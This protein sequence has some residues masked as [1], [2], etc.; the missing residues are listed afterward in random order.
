MVL[1]KEN[2][3]KRN[4][5]IGYSQGTWLSLVDANVTVFNIVFFPPREQAVQCLLPA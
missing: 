1:R 2:Y 3:V 5:S 4:L